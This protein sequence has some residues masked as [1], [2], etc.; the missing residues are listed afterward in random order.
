MMPP[1]NSTLPPNDLTLA[2]IA[3]IGGGNMATAIIGG[4]LR[5][6]RAPSS[7][8]VIDPS[9]EQRQ[10]LSSTLGVRTAAAPDASL[11][12]AHTV[13]WAV[14]PQQFKEA[15]VACANLTRGVPSQR[16]MSSVRRPAITL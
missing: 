6:G 16:A 14:K 10:R 8:L 7:I 2:D 15:A 9:D 1:M 13:V 5:Q 4:L 11:Q 3:F 12:A